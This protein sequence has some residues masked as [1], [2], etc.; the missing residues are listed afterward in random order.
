MRK[1]QW[2][3]LLIAVMVFCCSPAAQATTI[4]YS[5]A[6]A[7]GNQTWTGPLGMDFDVL[8]QI[9]ITALGAFDSDQDGIAV[10]IGVKGGGIAVSIYDRTSTASPLLTVLISGTGDFGVGGD[11]FMN[12]VS[13]L[14]L[15]PGQ[16][17]VVAV[18]FDAL[19][20][21]GNSYG[22]SNY[23][24]LDNGGGLIQFVGVSR[25]DIA[26]GYPTIIDGATARYGAGTFE[27]DSAVPEPSSLVLIGGGLLALGLLR[28][29]VW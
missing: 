23:P 6:T 17:S 28:R 11:V 10:P 26:G 1:T 21:N 20:Q 27:F 7:V 14:I 25:Y 8:S 16:Y 12:L 4:A 22:P 19:N 24:A 29:K 3:L 9:R 18:G 5:S 2:G 15:D 13:P